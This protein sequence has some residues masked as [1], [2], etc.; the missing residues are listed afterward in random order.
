MLDLLPLSI[1]DIQFFEEAYLLGSGTSQDQYIHDSITCEELQKVRVV[2][3]D[4]TLSKACSVEAEAHVAG[5][6]TRHLPSSAAI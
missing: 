4:A 5:H 1:K 2:L 6:T 3:Q